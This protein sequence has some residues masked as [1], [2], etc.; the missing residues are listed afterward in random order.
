M[1]LSLSGEWV[2]HICLSWL[3]PQCPAFKISLSLSLYWRIEETDT[4]TEVKTLYSSCLGFCVR[5]CSSGSC[6]WPCL[7]ESL[8]SYT[9]GTLMTTCWT[10]WR[11]VFP[12]TTRYTGL[13]KKFFKKTHTRVVGSVPRRCDRLV[14]VCY[15]HCFTN[16]YSVIEPFLSEFSNLCVGF[17]ALVTNP[18]AAEARDAARKIPLDRIL[19]ETD[20]P[21]F[22]PRQVSHS[23][24]TR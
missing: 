13:K 14:F 2:C 19:L 11:S 15:R 4:L 22:R 17:T 24:R 6:D 12:E 10:S 3:Y 16:S 1:C 7:W 23:F 20:A 8:W 21:Y 18:N 5:R 9:A